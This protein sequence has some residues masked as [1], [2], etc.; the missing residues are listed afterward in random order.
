LSS[1]AVA[2]DEQYESIP[3]DEIA[4][5][6][7]KLWVMHKFQK[8]RRTSS[9]NSRGCFE[10]GDTTHFIVDCPKRKKYNYSNR[11]DYGNKN[12]NKNDYKKKNRF[13]YKKKKKKKNVKKIISQAW[14]TSCPMLKS[15]LEAC[16]IEIKELK[17]RLDHSSLYKIFFTP[18]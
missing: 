18:L 10:C 17:K 7:R 5:L 2:F 1:F 12:D 4:L 6:A 9:Q 16:S 8:E 14:C 3:D 11:N 13:G 15:D